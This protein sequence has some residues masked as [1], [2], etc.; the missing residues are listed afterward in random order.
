MEK[1]KIIIIHYY[2][3][4]NSRHGFRTFY[5]KCYAWSFL[6]SVRVCFKMFKGFFNVNVC[7]LSIRLSAWLPLNEEAMGEI[8][9]FIRLKW[10]YEGQNFTGSNPGLF[11]ILFNNFTNGPLYYI[12]YISILLRLLT[13]LYGWNKEI[14]LAAFQMKIH[15]LKHTF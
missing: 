7:K 15:F 8:S 14:R 6:I 2:N 3:S 9:K 5:L 13:H 11:P 12:V 1:I 10:A 4:I